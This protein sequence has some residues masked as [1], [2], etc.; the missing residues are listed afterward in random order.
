[1]LDFRIKALRRAERSKGDLKREWKANQLW[2]CSSQGS[3]LELGEDSKRAE[4]CCSD[5]FCKLW[6]WALKSAFFFFFT[7]TNREPETQKG[8]P[9]LMLNYCFNLR[10]AVRQTIQMIS[11]CIPDS[12]T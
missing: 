12:Q 9:V 10:C 1:M 4:G 11:E 8:F 3:S 2:Q 5:V 6:R 7:S